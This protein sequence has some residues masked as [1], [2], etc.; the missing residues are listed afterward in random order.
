MIFVDKLIMNQHCK[1]KSWIYQAMK[2][3]Q[4][5]TILSRVD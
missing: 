4:E 5:G 1:A 3:T 2:F